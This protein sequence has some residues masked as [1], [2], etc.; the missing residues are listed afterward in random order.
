MLYQQN[1]IVYF[2]LSY[3]SI[4]YHSLYKLLWFVKILIILPCESCYLVFLCQLSEID[5]EIIGIIINEPFSAK[6]F[7]LWSQSRK[8]IMLIICQEKYLKFE[9]PDCKFQQCLTTTAIEKNFNHHDLSV[10]IID[11]RFFR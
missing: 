8:F 4:F 3:W 6:K 11:I 7:V 2:Y 10:I 1:F 5:L 9:I